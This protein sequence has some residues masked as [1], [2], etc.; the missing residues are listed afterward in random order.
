MGRV[1]WWPLPAL[2]PILLLLLLALS[3]YVTAAASQTL[4]VRMKKVVGNDLS[5]SS[6]MHP[7]HRMR[8]CG[9][10][11]Y[12]PI[13]VL[14][15]CMHAL[16]LFAGTAAAVSELLPAGL[17]VVG[18]YSSDSTAPWQPSSS[19]LPVVVINATS[20][21]AA[22]GATWSVNGQQQSGGLVAA[23]NATVTTDAADGGLQV[24][25]GFVPVR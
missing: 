4:Q 5:S 3:Q 14:F 20:T 9:Y 22:G 12:Y 19:T 1:S 16:L 17:H 24:A 15:P 13:A 23:T 6:F 2:L 21:G 7:M 18:S 25:P 8:H 11:T 10:T